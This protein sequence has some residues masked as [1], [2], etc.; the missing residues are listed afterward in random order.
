MSESTPLLPKHATSN[1]DGIQWRTLSTLVLAGLVLF[2][3]QTAGVMESIPLAE[4]TEDIICKS[5]I[6]QSESI[7]DVSADRCKQ[8]E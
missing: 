5:Y 7:A 4:I 8:P 3:A 2:L 1:H 6:S